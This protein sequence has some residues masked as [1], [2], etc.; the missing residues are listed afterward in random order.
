M[1][2]WC[3]IHENREVDVIVLLAVESEMG[4]RLVVGLGA[5]ALG[6]MN[7]VG[8]GCLSYGLGAKAVRLNVARLR[9]LSNGLRA[10]SDGL[11]VAGVCC[12]C[13]VWHIFINQWGF[14]WRRGGLVLQ[15]LLVYSP[16]LLN[17]V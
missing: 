14:H 16:R 3:W 11:N 5:K 9:C 6:L 10:E 8:L 1:L 17:L 7:V 13:C 2:L 15:I 12:W 4:R